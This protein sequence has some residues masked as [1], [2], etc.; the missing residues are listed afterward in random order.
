MLTAETRPTEIASSETPAAAIRE[1]L[2]LLVQDTAFRS[3]KRSVQ[4]LK[5]VVEQ[6]LHGAGDQIKERTIGVEV[7]G[8]DPSYDTNMDHVVRTA[9]IELRKRLAIYY[10]DKRHKSE[11]R[12]S[13]VPGSYKPRF[14]FSKPHW[15]GR[16]RYE[17]A[18][19]AAR[20]PYAIPMSGEHADTV[21]SAKPAASGIS[22]G[23]RAVQA[24]VSVC[25]LA[26]CTFLGYS[27][28][29]RPTAQDLFWKPELETPG[30]VLLAAG[31]VPNGPPTASVDAAEQGVPFPIVHETFIDDDSICGRDDNGAGIG[32]AGN[33]MAKRLSSGRR[34]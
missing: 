31:N 23:R 11:L 30:F 34:A 13:L 20:A 10:G 21:L 25:L 32:N 2:E 17:H 14:L 33:R 28:V 29:H 15:V 24:V 19:G 6:T 3:S 1:Q 4:F 18:G 16:S 8:R 5:Y 26:T 12:M 9:A 7:F 22:K 27:W